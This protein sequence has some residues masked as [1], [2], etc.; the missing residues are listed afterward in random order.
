MSPAPTS[1]S[2]SASPVTPS[3]PTKRMKV[4]M[5][6]DWCNSEQLCKE[7][8][9]MCERDFIWKNIEI[10]W[11]DSDDVDYYVI[12]NKP[13]NESDFYVPERTLVFPMEPTVFDETKHWGTKTWGKWAK[14]DPSVFFHVHDHARYLNNV[15]WLFRYPLSRLQDESTFYPSDKL[16]RVSCVSSRKMFDKGHILRNNLLRHIDDHYLDDKPVTKNPTDALQSF[17]NVFGSNNHFNYR[18]YVGKLP[19]DNIFYGIKP[20]KYYFMCENNSEHN[21]ATE[22]IW[23]PILCET[24][25]FYWGCPNLSDYID[26]R[27]FV[28]LDMNDVDASMRMMEQAIREDW[29]SQRIQYIRAA[30]HKIINELAF[31]PTL[32]SLIAPPAEYKQ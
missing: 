10:T 11:L 3:T 7:W 31:F 4:K 18:A 21:Y 16:S 20:Y 8:S 2:T 15:Q 23:E 5:L 6:C 28:Q 32:H 29:W 27:A 24:L 22:K 25:C 14:P 19:E 12:I 26:P 1:T 17:I 30:K 13:L 9:N